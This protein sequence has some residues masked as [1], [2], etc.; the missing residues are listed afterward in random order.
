M[1]DRNKVNTELLIDFYS[2]MDW[3][4]EETNKD[5][6]EYRLLTDNAQLSVDVGDV[7]MISLVRKIVDSVGLF[8]LF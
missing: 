4:I 7:L 3:I 2:C 5:R 6:W 1:I 8:F